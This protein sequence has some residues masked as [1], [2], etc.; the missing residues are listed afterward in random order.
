MVEFKQFII[1]LN[2]WR[3]GAV[4]SFN[5]VFRIKIY[6]VQN[7]SIQAGMYFFN[8]KFGGG[9]LSEVWTTPISNMYIIAPSTQTINKIK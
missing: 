7:I 9:G 6:F 4:C 1:F 2:K 8:T 3:K 5:L